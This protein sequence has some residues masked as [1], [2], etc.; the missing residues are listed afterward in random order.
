MPKLKG[1]H[2]M[3]CVISGEYSFKSRKLCKK[4]IELDFHTT[5]FGEKDLSDEFLQSN[6]LSVKN[7]SNLENDD[8]RLGLKN[9]PDVFFH[10]LHEDSFNSEINVENLEKNTSGL[11]RILEQAYYYDSQFILIGSS[12]INGQPDRL[13]SK[14]SQHFAEEIAQFYCEN[15]SLSL[16]IARHFEVFGP[17]SDKKNSLIY[18]LEHAKLFNHS[19]VYNGCENERKG[20]IHIDDLVSG[21]VALSKRTWNGQIFNFVM[22]KNYSILDLAQIFNI[23]DFRTNAIYKMEFWDAIPENS[24]TKSKLNWSPLNSVEGY[25]KSLNQNTKKNILC[26]MKNLFL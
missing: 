13:A 2:V 26:N 12:P 20:F 7:L 9:K 23:S 21:L 3:N 15:K 10:F 18:R 5:I 11:I 16:A 25:V 22:D 4:L 1:S 17:E 6:K 19:F 24:F 8:F 14:M